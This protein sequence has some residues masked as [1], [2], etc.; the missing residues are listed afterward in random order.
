MRL[1]F[2]QSAF[3]QFKKLD[4]NIQRR[5]DEKLRFYLSFSNPLR[6]AEPTK[7]DR[8]GDWKFR[9]GDYRVIFD[10]GDDKIFVLKIGHR[11]DIYK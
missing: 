3:R 9:I 4:R 10:A 1:F 2:S 7:D 8:F 6:F 5:I 11:R